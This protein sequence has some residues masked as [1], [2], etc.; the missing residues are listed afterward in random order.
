[1]A[2]TILILGANSDMAKACCDRFARQGQ[3]LYLAA[4]SPELLNADIQNYTIRYEIEAKSFAFDAQDIQSHEAFINNLPTLPDVVLCAVGYL[5][6][7]TKAQSNADEWQK[8]MSVNALGCISV[9][10]IIANRFEKRGSGVIAAISSVAGDRGRK[11]NYFY[12]SA[13]ACLTTYLSGLRNRLASKNVH[14]L[15]IKPGF[16]NTKMTQGM[17]LPTRL[18]ATSKQVAYA[19]DRAIT[20]QRN[21]IYVLPIWR[22]IMGIITRIPEPIFKRLSI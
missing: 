8:I 17:P 6:N 5:G 9:L 21:T 18:T 11:S 22:L 15:T 3:T 10:N 1:M 14:V 12:G 2:K 19:I 16:V 13:K 4:R 7:Q 20:K